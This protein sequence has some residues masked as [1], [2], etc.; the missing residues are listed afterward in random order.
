MTSLFQGHQTKRFSQH[1]F[2]KIVKSMP[3]YKTVEKMMQL[4]KEVKVCM[5]DFPGYKIKQS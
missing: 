1:F 5:D 4:S 3:I 2:H